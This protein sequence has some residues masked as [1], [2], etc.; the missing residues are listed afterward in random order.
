[1]K[2]DSCTEFFIDFV[3]VSFLISYRLFAAFFGK[4]HCFKDIMVRIIFS[5]ERE[6]N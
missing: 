2:L 3:L 1:M 4:T 6:L 5:T